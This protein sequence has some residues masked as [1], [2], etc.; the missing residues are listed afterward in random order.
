MTPPDP[1]SR[2]HRDAVIADLVRGNGPEFLDRE[3]FE[4]VKRSSLYERATFADA[5]DDL[6]A[7][8]ALAARSDARRI[9]DSLAALGVWLSRARR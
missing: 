3:T 7:A 8:V 6:L 5:C 1:R 9:M 4:S 2:R